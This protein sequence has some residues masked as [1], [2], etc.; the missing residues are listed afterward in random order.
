M[1]YFH[2]KGASVP[3]SKGIARLILLGSGFLF[4]SPRKADQ[5]GRQKAGLYLV[6][7][8]ESDGCRFAWLL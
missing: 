8:D 4:S 1:T 6:T 2:L 5:A 7:G 3:S